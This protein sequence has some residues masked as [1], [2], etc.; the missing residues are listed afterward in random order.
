MGIGSIVRLGF[1]LISA[2]VARMVMRSSSA[3]S[4]LRGESGIAPA[5]AMSRVKREV[6]EDSFMMRVRG[7]VLWGLFRRLLCVWL[8]V[9]LCVVRSGVS[10]ARKGREIPLYTFRSS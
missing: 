8:P 9:S 4:A 5:T 1:R 10:P 6:K 7:L 2:G 3:G